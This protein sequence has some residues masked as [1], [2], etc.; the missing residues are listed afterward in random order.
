MS[1]RGTR[2]GNDDYANELL[3]QWKGHKPVRS[4]ASACLLVGEHNGS[5]MMKEG[6]TEVLSFSWAHMDNE[7]G[8]YG[9]GMMAGVFPPPIS[10]RHV[11]PFTFFFT[12]CTV[13]TFDPSSSEER[14]HA[15]GKSPTKSTW[16][17]NAYVTLRSEEREGNL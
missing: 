13:P 7:V 10:F 9:T 2:E 17:A 4:P 12:V 6:G 11:D 3:R 1:E 15:Y 8:V 14:M 16:K 5:T